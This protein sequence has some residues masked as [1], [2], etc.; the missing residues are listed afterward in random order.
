MVS[1]WVYGQK[2]KIN[3]GIM[4]KKLTREQWVIVGLFL[5]FLIG[6]AFDRQGLGMILG[7]IAGFILGRK[8]PRSQST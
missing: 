3:K 6:A 4:L 7:V 5:G 2:R 8:S 1:G